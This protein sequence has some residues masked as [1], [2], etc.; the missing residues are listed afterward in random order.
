MVFFINSI[1]FSIRGTIGEYLLTMKCPT[2]KQYRFSVCF[3]NGFHAIIG[4]FICLIA[5][6]VL[7]QI[8][9]LSHF[10]ASNGML[11]DPYDFVSKVLSNTDMMIL[12]A[13]VCITEVAWRWTSNQIILRINFVAERITNS[14]R[15]IFVWIL[16][17]F[18]FENLQTSIS[19]TRHKTEPMW[20]WSYRKP[21]DAFIFV[22]FLAFIIASL[23]Y[24]EIGIPNSWKRQQ[25][26]T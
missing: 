23:L 13:I 11:C 7:S 22:Q 24:C 16:M 5:I 8:K 1:L 18:V 17:V 14:L 15:L 6:V 19:F 2:S 26:T 4:T 12:L 20:D 25:C 10:H 9:G 3:F 21:S